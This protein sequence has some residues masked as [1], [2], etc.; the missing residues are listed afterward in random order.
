MTGLFQDVLLFQFNLL[1]QAP[2]T[3]IN[4]WLINGYPPLQTVGKTKI[5][6]QCQACGYGRIITNKH[7]LTTYILKNPPT[8]EESAALSTGKK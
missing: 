4:Y 8:A 3:L 1:L 5:R 6:Q 2:P 7:R